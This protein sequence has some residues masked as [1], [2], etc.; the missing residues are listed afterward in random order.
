MMIDLLEK[1]D[2]ISKFGTE[3][4]SQDYVQELCGEASE[5]LA[6]LEA[7]LSTP[8]HKGLSC[9]RDPCFGGE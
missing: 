1:L 6:E 3:Q 4:V 8:K 9:D 5:R 2:Q 7:K